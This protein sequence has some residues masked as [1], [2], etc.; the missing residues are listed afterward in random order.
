M[1]CLPRIL[2]P[3]IENA[4]Y[5][6]AEFM[7]GNRNPQMLS[8]TLIFSGEVMKNSMVRPRLL[9]IQPLAT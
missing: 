2:V 5:K 6:Q 8:N 4:T 7:I 1:P 3:T 9:Y